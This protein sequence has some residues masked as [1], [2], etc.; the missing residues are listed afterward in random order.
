MSLFY[1]LE[2]NWSTRYFTAAR[3]SARPLNICASTSTVLFHKINRLGVLLDV[4][5]TNNVT[6]DKGELYR[7]LIA[8]G[9]VPPYLHASLYNNRKTLSRTL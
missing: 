7:L 9:F 8:K 2:E 6:S 4:Y 1:L 5:I 3:H